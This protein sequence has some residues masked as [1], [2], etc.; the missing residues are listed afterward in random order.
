[1]IL[2][3]VH[4]LLRKDVT[5]E[6]SK[7]RFKQNFKIQNLNLTIALSKRLLEGGPGIR[8]LLLLKLTEVRV[9]KE[10]HLRS[11]YSDC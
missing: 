5:T 10:K 11:Q 7:R 2:I 6:D 9:A 1:M 3:N 8:P 4:I